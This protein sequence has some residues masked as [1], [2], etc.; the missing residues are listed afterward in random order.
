MKT[1]IIRYYP[2]N[3]KHEQVKLTALFAGAP[4]LTNNSIARSVLPSL[5]NDAA[6]RATY[7][8]NTSAP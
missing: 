5:I 3:I 1:L 8:D 4:Y 7:L 6:N 2:V